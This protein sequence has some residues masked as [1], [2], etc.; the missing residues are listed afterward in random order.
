M[1]GPVLAC[2]LEWTEDAWCLLACLLACLLEY[3][4]SRR[5]QMTEMFADVK[6]GTNPSLEVESDKDDVIANVL[7]DYESDCIVVATRV[8]K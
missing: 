5:M 7:S 3:T 6:G 8:N 4:R 2:L 1:R